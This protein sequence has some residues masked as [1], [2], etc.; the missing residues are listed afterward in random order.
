MPFPLAPGGPRRS[1]HLRSSF[2][3]RGSSATDQWPEPDVT[4]RLST[5]HDKD[6]ESRRRLASLNDRPPP[7]APVLVAETA[8]IR[9]RR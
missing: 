2:A 3:A 9:S 5:L 6:C 1:E 4:V 7:R 8:A